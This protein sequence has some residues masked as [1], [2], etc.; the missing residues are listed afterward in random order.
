MEINIRNVGMEVHITHININHGTLFWS[1]VIILYA[2]PV[3]K[4]EIN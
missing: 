2:R 1:R 3:L 4:L